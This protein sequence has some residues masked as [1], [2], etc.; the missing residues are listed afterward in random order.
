[1][2]RVLALATYRAIRRPWVI[3]PREHEHEEVPSPDLM[4]KVNGKFIYLHSDGNTH[5]LGTLLELV[6]PFQQWTQEGGAWRD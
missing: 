4:E 1:M 5:Y 6:C 3:L 2:R